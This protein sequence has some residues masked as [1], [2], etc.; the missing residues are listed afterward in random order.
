MLLSVLLLRY[1]L[2]AARR[3]LGAGRHVAAWLVPDALL[4]LVHLSILVHTGELALA[5]FGMIVL[6]W[7][8]LRALA[9]HPIQ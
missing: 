8:V 4:S 5:T 6:A 1:L 9:C 2:R 3:C 7:L